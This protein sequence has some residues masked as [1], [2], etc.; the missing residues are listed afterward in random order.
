MG[1]LPRLVFAVTRL[2]RGPGWSHT[3]GASFVI[4]AFKIDSVRVPGGL[5]VGGEVDVPSQVGA[6]PQDGIAG[7]M[8]MRA[9]RGTG[10]A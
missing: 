6:A 7:L 4:R 1:Y 3:K 9:L 10:F 5:G 2:L 8:H